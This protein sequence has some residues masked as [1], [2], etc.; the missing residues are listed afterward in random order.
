MAVFASGARQKVDR[1][2]AIVGGLA[3]LVGIAAVIWAATTPDAAVP[4]TVT[5]AV[6]SPVP[7]APVTMTVQSTQPPTR[8]TNPPRI[9]QESTVTEGTGAG[10]VV[11]TTTPGVAAQPLLGSDVASITTQVILVTLAAL[12]LGFATQRLLL[13]VYGMRPAFA[14]GGYE[15]ID[16]GEAIAVKKDVLAAGE[17]P[18]LSRPLFERSGVTDPRLKLLQSRI[19]LELEVRKLAQHNDLPSGLTV[20]YVVRGLVSKKKMSPKLASAVTA[21]HAIGDRLGNGAE[22][23]ADTTTLLMEAYSQALAKLGGR[24]KR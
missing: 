11:V 7:G 20:P 18:D 19:A 17:A 8:P 2:A 6:S 23:S 12:L 4:S 10:E 24:I 9:T 5:T 16:E 22:L 21:L 13:G 14:R 3:F 15:S 1:I